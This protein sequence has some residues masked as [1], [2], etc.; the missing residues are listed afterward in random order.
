M[1]VRLGML[2]VS[3]LLSPLAW[4]DAGES[5]GWRE[6]CAAELRAYLGTADAPLRV[7]GVEIKAR[8]LLKEVYAR[9]DH[10][11]LWHETTRHELAAAVADSVND[12]LSPQDY[13]HEGPAPGSTLPARTCAAQDL[14]LSESLLRLAYS[15][16]F[17]RTDPR[18]I[19]RTW[20][21]PR[22]LGEA[23][24]V[25]WFRATMRTGKLTAALDALRP[26]AVWYARLRM[27]H[28]AL[29]GQAG[30]PEWPQL[31]QGPS[32][33]LGMVH[34][35][36]QHLRRRLAA[37]SGN[38]LPQQTHADLYDAALDAQVRAFQATH[39]LLADG[40]VGAHTRAALNVPRAARIAQLRVNLERLRWIA[41]EL[42]ARF[43]AVNIASF[44]AGLV[45]EGRLLW[46]AR[47][48]VGRPYRQTPVF[49]SRIE[50]VE[51]NPYW[52]VPPGILKH[53]VL[54]ALQRDPGYLAAKGLQV[55]DAQGAVIDP[56]TLDWTQFQ[57]GNFPYVL[58]QPPG[59]DN[60]LGRIKFL[61]PNP[62]TVY[63]HD[64]PARD[65][66]AQQ[67]RVFSSGCI[68]IERPFE[69]ASLLL[70]GDPAWPPDK[71]Q[72]ALQSGVRT[73]IRLREPLPIL[74]LYLTAYV[75]T[76]N[77]VNFRED[78]YAR[79]GKVLQA[80]EGAFHFSLPADY[81]APSAKH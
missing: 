74:L 18:E 7:G 32:L 77:T 39:G 33:R 23:Q 65:L 48:I 47:T 69:L 62:Y 57:R 59:D 73:P 78:V 64:T 72:A 26:D 19:S 45:A 80:L 43:L 40:V 1:P 9:G 22:H 3:L 38:N 61:F 66:F 21:Y 11:P 36:V 34:P 54:P 49:R 60:S 71:V 6:R 50:S 20:N 53:D 24:A 52:T 10:Q 12:G 63:L 75:D 13:P 79:D 29:L 15:L 5:T 42:P 17:G 58:R 25:D 46:R 68:R 56:A 41:H 31:G 8:A 55:I 27:A 14:K 4:A 70:A 44:E 37:A 30:A 2:L 67:S 76:E 16:R 51:I 81:S 35:E 28:A